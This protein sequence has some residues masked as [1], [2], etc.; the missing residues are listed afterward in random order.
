[1]DTQNPL[2]P[3][4]FR[5]PH[6][7]ARPAVVVLILACSV[8][9][10]A[11]ETEDFEAFARTAEMEDAGESLEPGDEKFVKDDWFVRIGIMGGA[12]PG[13]MGS[14]HYEGSY[15][16][17]GKIVWRDLVFLNDRQLGVN[18]YKDEHLSV[19]PY[20]RYNGGRSDDNDGLEG[21]GDID[22]TMTAGAFFNYRL[23]VVRFKSEVRH[24][25]LGQDQG[26]LAI[27]RLGTRVPWSA[28]AVTLYASTSWASD[29]YMNSFFG[30]NA[31]QSVRA[32]LPV[33]DPGSGIR[34]VSLSLS[35]GY[36]ISKHWALGGQVEYQRLLGDAADSPIVDEQGSRNQFVIGLGLNYTF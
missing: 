12:V 35:S 28:P 27:V 36:Q 30:V 5:R 33:Y 24:D 34:D 11:Q 22:R 18:L 15:T 8:G 13:Y 21:M 25:V 29:T 7:V 16:P 23:G 31:A 17:R 20:L 3:E 19:G 9:V 2:I 14:D 26:T 32:A 6:P 4:D 1:M 10:P